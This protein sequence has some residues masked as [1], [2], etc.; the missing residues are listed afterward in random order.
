M[1]PLLFLLLHLTLTLTCAVHVL[2]R[3]HRQ[4]ESRVAWLLMLVA[5]PYLG[6]L[7]YLLFGT[8]QIGRRRA[9]RTK[10]RRCFA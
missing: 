10:T 7:A 9:E 4:P 5:F 1:T 2:L 8:T 6:V 3:A